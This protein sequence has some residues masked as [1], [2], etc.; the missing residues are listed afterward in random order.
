MPDK[1]NRPA[2]ILLDVFVVIGIVGGVA[3]SIGFGV[4]LVSSL[5]SEL[6]NI[7]DNISLQLLVIALW[8]IIFGT[9]SYLGLKRGIKVLSDFNVWLFFI[10]MA[11]VLLAGPTLYLLDITVNSVGLWL[12]NFIRMSFW[13]DPI[14]KEDFRSLDYIL[15][16]LVDRLCSMM[17]LFF[18]RISRG[19]L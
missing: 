1:K 9:S 8:T 17:G 13:T 18:A 10:L 5:L 14:Q 12:N 11:I 2:W 15:L 19:G 3:T 6:F 16:G 7:E 4:P